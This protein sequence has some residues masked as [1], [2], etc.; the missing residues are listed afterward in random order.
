MV[1]P[2]SILGTGAAPL[3]ANEEAR[4]SALAAYEQAGATRRTAEMDRIA[5]LAATLMSVPIGLVSLV[6]RDEQ[7]FAGNFGLEGMES[8]DRD[9][10]FCAHTILGDEP[11]VV[12][13][14]TRDA[15]FDENPVVTGDFGLRYYAGAPIFS[16]TTGHR[17]GALCVIDKSPRAETTP[18][19]RALLTD[20][21]QMAAE[22][23]EEN[24]ASS[25]TT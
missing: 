17:L 25:S 6:G 18:A 7:R 10:S 4:L 24:M 2:T 1:S 14:A 11:F 15:R 5:K 22:L 19:E 23:I 20:L 16:V 9:I 13:D 8:T 12:P 3:A 21:A